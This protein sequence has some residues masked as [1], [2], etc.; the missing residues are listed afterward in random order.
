[1]SKYDEFKNI[2]NTDAQDPLSPPLAQSNADS[3]VPTDVNLKPHPAFSIVKN[4]IFEMY[5]I[6][7][8]KENNQDK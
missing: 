2:N 3:S 5:D 6:H 8:E 1:M 7:P 4:R